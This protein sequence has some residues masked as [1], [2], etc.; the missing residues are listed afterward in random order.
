MAEPAAF[1][2]DLIF[3]RQGGVLA[4]VAL[5]VAYAYGSGWR[6]SALKDRMDVVWVAVAALGM[7][8]LVH[9]TWRYIGP[10]MVLF[11][12]GLLALVRLPE[13]L[14]NRRLLAI[15]GAA[16]TIRQGAGVVR[17]VPFEAR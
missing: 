9:V 17:Q 12:S 5:L 3:R 11:W 4:V 6:W 13:G 1:Y 7:Y 14:P 8:A 2:F 10:Y 16:I 15:A